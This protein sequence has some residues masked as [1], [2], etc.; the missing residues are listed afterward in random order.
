MNRSYIS[1]VLKCPFNYIIDENDAI[2]DGLMIA[3]L[4]RALRS[5]IDRRNWE[6]IDAGKFGC[7]VAYD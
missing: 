6:P 2:F 1:K 5:P 4:P 7:D 3:E